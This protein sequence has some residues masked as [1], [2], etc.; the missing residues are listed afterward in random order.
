M[1]LKVE[2][3]KQTRFW[4]PFTTKQGTYISN[5]MVATVVIDV[6]GGG[7]GGVVSCGGGGC[8]GFIGDGG[9]VSAIGIRLGKTEAQVL[10]ISLL[11]SSDKTRSDACC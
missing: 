6:G 7:S 2:A 3:S 8:G 10:F 9:V 5:A 11:L 1:H 4:K